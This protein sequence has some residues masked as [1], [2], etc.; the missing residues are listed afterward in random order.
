MV[1][2]WG[3]PI[4]VMIAAYVVT[5]SPML[6]ISLVLFLVVW[7]GVWAPIGLSRV[8]SR[9]TVRELGI[10]PVHLRAKAEGA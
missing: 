3:W 1:V 8:C 10:C 6:L 9:C 5:R 2:G 4:A 7:F